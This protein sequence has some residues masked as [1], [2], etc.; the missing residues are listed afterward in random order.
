MTTLAE[1]YANR[2]QYSKSEEV[3]DQVLKLQR[4]YNSPEGNVLM[5]VVNLGWVRLQQKKYSEAESTLKEASDG[6]RRVVPNSTERY[7]AEIT[8]GAC[9]AAQRRFEQAE[10]LLLSGYE[11]IGRKQT[12]WVEKLKPRK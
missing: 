2:N 4:Q 9:L 6:L 1:N 12:E 10:P 8:L 7:Y 11:G 3:L 5:T